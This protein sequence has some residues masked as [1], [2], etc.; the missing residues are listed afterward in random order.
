MQAQRIVGAHTIKNVQIVTTGAE[1]IFDVYFEPTNRRMALHEVAIVSG[2]QADARAH[3]TCVTIS[4]VQKR[5]L[6]LARANPIGMHIIAITVNHGKR[7]VGLRII[8][9]MRSWTR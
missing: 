5:W 9:T 3:W 2:S 7:T 4:H 6:A 8:V 1:I